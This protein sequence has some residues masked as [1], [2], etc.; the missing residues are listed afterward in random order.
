MA[1]HDTP[2]SWII[3]VLIDIHDYAER[4]N[5]GEVADQIAATLNRVSPLI[6]KMPP[7]PTGATVVPLFASSPRIPSR[8]SVTET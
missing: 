2:H 1:R 7:A 4:E 5:I 8:A 3:H 6:Q